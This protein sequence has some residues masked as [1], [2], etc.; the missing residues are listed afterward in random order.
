MSIDQYENGNFTDEQKVAIRKVDQA[1]EEL[2]KALGVKD[3]DGFLFAAT[4]SL[5]DLLRD[6]LDQG[7]QL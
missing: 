4:A 7:E 6:G 1:I 2:G 5:D 3:V